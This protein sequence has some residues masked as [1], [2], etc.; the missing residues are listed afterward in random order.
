MPGVAAMSNS[1]HEVPSLSKQN[2]AARKQLT[3]LPNGIGAKPFK[4]D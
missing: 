3:V 2:C 1:D 4:G